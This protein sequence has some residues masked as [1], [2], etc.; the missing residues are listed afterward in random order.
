[1]DQSVDPKF[2]AAATKKFPSLPPRA[3]CAA[4]WIETYCIHY[5]GRLRGQHFKLIPWELEALAGMYP[6]EPYDPRIITRVFLSMARKNGKTEFCSCLVLLHLA[7]TEAGWNMQVICAAAANQRQAGLVWDEA[8]KSY[9]T[10]KG[11]ARKTSN[12]FPAMGRGIVSDPKRKCPK[13]YT[14]PSPHF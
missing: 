9:P 14:N 12:E 11:S 13:D 6:G 4:H 3:A 1:M 5:K 8:V 2:Y 10:R 7:G